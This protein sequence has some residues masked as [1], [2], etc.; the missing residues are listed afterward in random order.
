MSQK[1]SF[2]VFDNYPIKVVDNFYVT[3][4]GSSINDIVN[5]GNY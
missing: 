3:D 1:V 2:K 5:S 4:D